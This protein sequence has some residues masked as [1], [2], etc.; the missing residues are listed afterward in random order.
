MPFGSL[1]ELQE[2]NI[3]YIAIIISIIITAGTPPAETTRVPLEVN[4]PPGY[5]AI[6]PVLLK[7]GKV[8]NPYPNVD[9]HSGQLMF[10]GDLFVLSVKICEVLWVSRFGGW[11][12]KILQQTNTGMEILPFFEWTFHDVHMWTLQMLHGNVR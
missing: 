7:Q 1:P 10:L 11:V 3:A 4:Q 2:F 9:A 12:K 5:H 8:K 6:P